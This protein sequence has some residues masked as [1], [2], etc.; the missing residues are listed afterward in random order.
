MGYTVQSPWIQTAAAPQFTRDQALAIV[1]QYVKNENLRRHMYACEALM[2]A[3]AAHYQ[4][5]PE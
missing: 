2:K 1:H 3:Y 4:D 5:D